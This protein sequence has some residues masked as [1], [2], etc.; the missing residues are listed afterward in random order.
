MT[1]TAKIFAGLVLFVVLVLT[2]IMFAAYGRANAPEQ[3][4]KFSHK[5]HAGDFG[6]ACEYCH[7]Y[8]RRSTVAG[9]PSVARCMGCHKVTALDK[10]EVKKLADYWNRKEPI[11]WVKVFDQPDFVYFSHQPHIAKGIACQSCHGAVEQM[12]KVREAVVV[13]MARCVNCH[14][15]KKASID[16]WTCHK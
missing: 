4:I 6:I 15:E 10:P 16:C 1:R 12:E 2:G 11:P 14:M 7:S 8:A 3:P 5:V 9:V 13:N